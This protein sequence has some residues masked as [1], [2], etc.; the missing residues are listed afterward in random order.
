MTNALDAKFPNETGRPS[1]IQCSQKSPVFAN[2]I[3]HPRRPGGFRLV[4]PSAPVHYERKL[5]VILISRASGRSEDQRAGFDGRE[6][7]GPGAR[8]RGPMHSLTRAIAVALT[9]FGASVVGMALQW[10][11]PAQVLTEA[12]GTVGAMAG[13]VTLLL[14]LVLGLLIWTAFSVFTTQQAEA[15][16]LGPVIIELDVIL[17]Q[18][19]P[20][21]TRGRVGLVVAL[22]GARNGFFGDVKHAPQAHTFEETRATMHL[23]NTYFDSLSPPTERQRQLLISARDLAKKFAETQMLMTRQLSDPFPPYLLVVVVC[24]ASAL[25]LGNGLVA[26]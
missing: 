20:E 23:M 3:S 6:P 11:V 14:A 24:W 4:R 15:Q 18:Y 8:R 25:F 26:T 7:K 10:V 2:R 12:K 9:T 5:A 21:A 13:L 1:H 16:S 19:G 17:E 22:G